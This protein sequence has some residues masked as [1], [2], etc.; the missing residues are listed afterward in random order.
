M[1]G[2]LI[3]L[4]VAAALAVPMLGILAAIA[5]PAYNDYLLR[6]KIARDVDVPA[7]AMRPA[8][9]AAQAR[10]GRCPGEVDELGAATS[11]AAEVRIGELA[12]GQCAFEI[13]LRGIDARVDGKTVLHVAPDAE[14]GDWDCTG[15]SLDARFRPAA[16]RASSTDETP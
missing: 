5:V 8:V 4:I 10:L 6:T 14:D 1:S 9:E 11:T 2:C 13:T 12:S 15:G 16:C 7:M 3:A